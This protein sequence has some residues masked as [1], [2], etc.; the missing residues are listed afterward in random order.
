M[1]TNPDELV[2]YN[3]VLMSIKDVPDPAIR[4][5]M[6]PGHFRDGRPVVPGDWPYTPETCIYTD[7]REGTKW[8]NGGQTLVCTGCGLDGT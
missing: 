1:P 7:P 3:G 8:I 2:D 4:H 6:G 5:L